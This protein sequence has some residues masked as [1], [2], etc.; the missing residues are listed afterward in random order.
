MTS[1]NTKSSDASKY[2]KYT[3]TTPEWHYLKI[4]INF[5]SPTKPLPIITPL[6]LRTLITKSLTEAFGIIGSGTH[7]DILNWDGEQESSDY[8]G[9]LRVPREDLSTLWSSL[10]L[11]NATL[12]VDN[13]NNKEIFFEVLCNSSFLMGLAV[14]SRD[15]TRRLLNS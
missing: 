3:I 1:S 10:T 9:I 15:W 12:H 2:V 6:M 8:S 14:D 13:Q 5:D 11:F 4:R 7:V